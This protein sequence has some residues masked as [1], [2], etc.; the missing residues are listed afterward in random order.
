AR[1]LTSARRCSTAKSNGAASPD[2]ST[3]STSATIRR[4]IVADPQLH[5]LLCRWK[6]I[7]VLRDSLQTDLDSKPAMRRRAVVLPHPDGPRRVTNSPWAMSSETSSTA[8]TS[9]S[10][11]R[12][13]KVLVRCSRVRYLPDI[14]APLSGTLVKS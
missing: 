8:V 12:T 5:A 6:H 7:Q 3:P 14:V 1:S 13:G 9:P 10:R 4:I 11:V 2:E